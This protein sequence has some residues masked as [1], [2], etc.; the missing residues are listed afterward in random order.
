SGL[1]GGLKAPDPL[2]YGCASCGGE[3]CANC[4]P[5]RKPC[6][7]QLAES[8]LGRFCGGIYNCIRCPDP[9]YEGKWYPLAGAAFFTE[10]VRPVT[11]QRFRWLSGNNVV[12]PDRS[13]FFWARAD[14]SGKGPK[15]PS[16]FLGERRL[17]Y[18][19]LILV[20]EG[21]TGTITVIAETAY[22]NL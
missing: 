21:G 1:I 3:G 2:D 10:A 19:D 8:V 13:E 12:L 9:C 7:P 16:G 4:V 17:R 14:G 11:Q 20:T 22:R 5:G 18:N 15:P 6:D